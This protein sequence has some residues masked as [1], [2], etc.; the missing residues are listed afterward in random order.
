MK[1]LT[2]YDDLATRELAW[3]AIDDEKWDSPQS[4][5]GRGATEIEAVREL[6]DRI[7]E[8]AERASRTNG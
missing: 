2:W 1:I 7:E 3:C 4:P 8:N 5:T 6:L